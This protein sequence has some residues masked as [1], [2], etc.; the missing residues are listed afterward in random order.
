MS[1]FKKVFSKYSWNEIT[2]KIS[3]IKTEDVEKALSKNQ[4]SI[5]DFIALISP[6]AT[7]FIE[8]MAQKSQALTQQHFG[9]NIQ[10]YAPLYLSNECQNI[11][12][13]CGFSLTNKIPRKTLSEKEMRMEMEF[14]KNQGFEHIL[15]V[16]GE[17]NM[18]VGV[19]YLKHAV[20]IAKEYFSNISIEVQPLKEDEYKTL[21]E[22]GLHSVL[23]YQ[24][25]YNKENYG[26]YHP[27]GKKSNFEFRLNT[28]D[29][30]AIS[31]VHKIGIGFLIG[32]EEWRTEA[33]FTA[34]HLQYLRKKYWKTQYSI[35][36]PRLKNHE[37]EFVPNYEL[38][39]IEFVQ[40]IL[41]FRLFDHQIELSLSTR[42]KAEF[43]NSLIP[44]GITSISAGSRTS[45]GGYVVAPQELEQFEIEDNRTPKQMSEQVLKLGYEPVWKNWD[46][47]YSN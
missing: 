44:L 7:P 42:E 21:V 45:P 22:N 3:S 4:I 28:A 31:D 14:L 24:E 29:R 1:N 6:K 39:D 38:N 27:K 9:K 15:I 30:A 40:L 18:T 43:R 34:L 26:I 8:K 35:S 41:A 13:Y 37:G 17:A 25:T 20:N 33:F 12:T 47:T 10:F 32:L 5:D 19:S 2:E 11:C 46:L 16:T 36:F 23:V